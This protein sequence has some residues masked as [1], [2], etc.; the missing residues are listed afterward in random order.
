MSRVN[1]AYVVNR[2]G[3][4]LSWNFPQ[5]EAYK[6]HLMAGGERNGGLGHVGGYRRD[7]RSWDESNCS[8]ISSVKDEGEGKQALLP[9]V[10]VGPSKT[11][12]WNWSRLLEQVDL[13]LEAGS[14]AIGERLRFPD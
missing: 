3:C 6:R 12:L 8:E 5:P 7:C 1:N 9:K 14:P 10:F 13:H 2:I 4:A 11:L